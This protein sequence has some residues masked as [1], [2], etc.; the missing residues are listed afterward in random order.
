MT[1]SHKIDILTLLSI[2]VTV[3]NITSKS[4][5][6]MAHVNF[7]GNVYLSDKS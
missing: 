2:I 4:V 7:E 5:I 6:F 1:D 3:L